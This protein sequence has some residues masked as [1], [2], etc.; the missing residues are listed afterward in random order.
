M[1]IV[2]N[3]VTVFSVSLLCIP[4]IAEQSYIA[5]LAPES[6][7]LDIDIDGKEVVVVGERGHILRSTDGVH[8]QQDAVPSLSTLTAVEKIGD[9]V[10]VVGHDALILH[11]GPQQSDWQVQMFDPELQKPFLD[12]LFFDDAHGIAVGAYGTFFRTR[13]GGARW[14]KEMHP[15]LLH[16]DDQLYLDEIRLEDEEFYQLELSSIL[17]HINRVMLQGDTVYMAGEAGLLAKSADNGQSWQRMDVNYTGSFFDITAAPTGDVVA[18]GLRGNM[19][20][21]AA[22]SQQ[23]RKVQ[24]NNTNSLN[25]VIFTGPGQ[26]VAIGNGGMLVCSDNDEIETVQTDD[27]KALI[28]AAIYNEQLLSVTAEGI[29]H[30][31]LKTKSNACQGVRSSL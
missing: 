5:K 30:I 19:F 26:Y 25:S 10:W 28:A 3:L 18:V 24:S 1:S 21:L 4:A 13:D 6:L 12:V 22:E 7:L 23:W 9:H 2:K 11:K 15:E 14:L 17:P 8:W 27:G 20:V 29:K 16:P 31:P